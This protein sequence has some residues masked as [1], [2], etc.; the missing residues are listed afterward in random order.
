MS[1]IP[2]DDL[3]AGDEDPPSPH[4]GPFPCHVVRQEEEDVPLE[5][6]E[7]NHPAMSGP[8]T[9]PSELVEPGRLASSR[10]STVAMEPAETGL[11][12]PSEPSAAPLE[13]VGVGRFDSFEPSKPREGSKWQCANEEQLGLGK[14]DPKHPRMMASR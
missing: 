14:P 11:P 4:A 8:L 6:A 3:A 9:A 12:S 13:S 7:M 2:W 1:P 5:L 10:P